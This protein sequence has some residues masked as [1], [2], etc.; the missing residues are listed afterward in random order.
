MRQIN[1]SLPLLLLGIVIWGCLVQLV[2]IW[3]VEDK[4]RYSTGTWIGVS[5]AVFMAI[6]LALVIESAVDRGSS[7]GVLRF[8]SILRYLVVIIVFFVM[9]YFNLGNWISAFIAVMGLKVSAYAQP[10]IIKIIHKERI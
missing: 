9:I 8:K 6:N 10:F 2:G 1:S 7:V 5:L 4:L 3:F